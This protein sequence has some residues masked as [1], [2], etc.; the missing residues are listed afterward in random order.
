MSVSIFGWDEATEASL[1]AD[2]VRYWVGVARLA[3]LTDSRRWPRRLAGMHINPWRKQLEYRCARA[4]RNMAIIEAQNWSKGDI[5]VLSMDAEGVLF[6]ITPDERETAAVMLWT[7]WLEEA[8]GVWREQRAQFA[9]WAARVDAGRFTA[10]GDNRFART[11]GEL[12]RI[13][14]RHASGIAPLRSRGES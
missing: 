14:D 12:V 6:D 3:Y 13:Y 8:V 5:E 9:A 2:A 4:V 11:L 7:V 1:R 10:Q